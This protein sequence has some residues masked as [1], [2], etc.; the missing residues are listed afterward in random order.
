MPNPANLSLSPRK[1]AEREIGRVQVHLAWLALISLILLAAAF[2]ARADEFATLVSALGADS[3]VEKAQ[4]ITA[5]GKLGDGRAVAVLTA[6][7]DGR[8]LKAPDGRVMVSD[9]TKL[10]DPLPGADVPAS[11]ANAADLAKMQGDWMVVST[12]IDGSK[13]SNDEA[14]TLFRTVDGNKYSIFR[15]SKA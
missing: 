9:A 7:N 12:T 14:Q 1:W 11:A 8:L 4:A 10:I 13:L 6:L 15:F 2:P 5:L 3:F